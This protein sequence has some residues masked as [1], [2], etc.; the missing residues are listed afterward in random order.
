MG[1]GISGL[2]S[3]GLKRGN[4]SNMSDVVLVLGMHRS[5]TSAVAGTV[6]KL[7]GALPLHLMPAHNSNAR[8][9]FE[10]VSLMGFHDELLASAGSE[11]SDW[12]AF[13]PGWNQSPA[14]AD[15]RRRAKALF[16]EEFE[17]SP[18]PVLKDPRICRFASFWLDTLREMSATPHIVMPIRSPLDVAQSLKTLHGLSL[19]HGLLLWLR[20][21][22]DA[23]SQTRSLARSIFS[24]N[25]FQSDWRGVCDKIAAD[26][27]LSWPRLSD[28]ASLEIDRFLTKDL[29]HHDTDDVAL[30]G[31]AD[32]H[33]WVL[34]VY[35]ALL[36][37]RRNPLANS[38]LATLDDVRLL[39]DDSSQIFGR[40]L[41]DGEMDL[42]DVRGQSQAAI[43]ERDALR[44]RQSEILAEKA[45]ALAEL[46]ARAET[47]ERARE[48]AERQIEALQ[49]SLAA[50]L[51]QRDALSAAQADSAAE[52]QSLLRALAEKSAVSAELA[53]RAE[54]AE[55]ARMEAMRESE[56]LSHSL[57]AALA[58]RDALGAAQAY[59]ASQAQSLR[60]ELAEKQTALVELAARSQATEAALGD[61][62]R[63]RAELAERIA[64]AVADLQSLREALAERSA[65]LVEHAARAGGAETALRDA[66]SVNE[67]LAQSLAAVLAERDA[68]LRQ[69]DEQAEK[70]AQSL[71]AA[72]TER[73]AALRQADE[74]AEKQAQ[75]LAAALAERDAA[76]RQADEQAEKQAQSLAALGAAR[77]AQA[78]KEAALAALTGDLDRERSERQS[79]AGRLEQVAAESQRTRD[80]ANERATAQSKALAEAQR[81]HEMRLG[82]LRAELVDAEA[83]LARAGVESARKGFGAWLVPASL[84]RRRIARRLLRSGLFDA[85]FYRQQYPEAMAASETSELAAATHYIEV[86]FCRGFRP[87]P[88]FDTHWYLERYEDVRRAGVN[89]LLHYMLHGWREGRDP[90]PGFQTEFYLAANA[91]VRASGANPLAHYLRY[92]RHEGRLAAQR[93]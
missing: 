16:A 80:L 59:A 76:L 39:L 64:V 2:V 9:F 71:A 13:N 75:S 1:N 58:E 40:L 85:N 36:E 48:A 65:I 77:V 38:A 31:R 5:G 30:A 7:G 19:T 41:I 28:R 92:G 37:L 70:Q 81:A 93:A 56:A 91:D 29:V 69:A 24:W 55:R 17:G 6:A 79:L 43:T 27:H 72:L 26:T 11:W 74:Q 34:R 14:A 4:D 66:V 18:L 78:G 88:L 84:R 73:D 25:D 87:N 46:A 8:G 60:L 89:P 52:V 67:A 90:G 61:A 82:A 21:V 45:T 54:T 50:A 15:F 42:K 53:A 3:W 86:G 20:H 44:E 62:A 35:Q 47:A 51:A 57:A 63:D 32:V 68:A 83:G 23:E 33:Q 10:S 12:R 22:L 49:H